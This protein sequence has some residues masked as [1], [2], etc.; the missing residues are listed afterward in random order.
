MCSWHVGLDIF[1]SRF[2][3]YHPFRTTVQTVMLGSGMDEYESAM[4]GLEA[5]HPAHFRGWVGFS[6]PVAHRIV[7]GDPCCR[8]TRALCGSSSELLS[9]RTK[10]D[11]LLQGHDHWL[12]C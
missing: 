6:I 5:A 2:R 10:M 1:A 8:H 4:R 3:T 11:S 9:I 7:A 12:L